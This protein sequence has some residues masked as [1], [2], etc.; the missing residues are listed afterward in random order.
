MDRIRNIFENETA[1]DASYEPLE[2][3]SERPD[4]QRIEEASH[5]AFSWADYSVFLLM[6][7]AMLWAWYACSALRTNTH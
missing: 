5:G 4:G 3:G 7:V 6:G 2:G 1:R